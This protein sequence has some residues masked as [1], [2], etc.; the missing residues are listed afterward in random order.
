MNLRKQRMNRLWKCSGKDLVARKE[1][2]NM[3]LEITERFKNLDLK[4]S[5][6]NKNRV[7]PVFINRYQLN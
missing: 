1:L 2:D 5:K 4:H 7:V 3:T 6:N